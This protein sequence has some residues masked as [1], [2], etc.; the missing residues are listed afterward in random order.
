[1]TMLTRLVFLAIVL[2]TLDG[3]AGLNAR[4]E[5][6]IGVK[7]YADQ[8]LPEYKIYI[9]NDISLKQNDKRIR[10]QTADEFKRYIEQY[11]R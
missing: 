5:F 4:K 8:I 6:A 1:M 11:S 2:V 9:E 3:C 10:K 7:V